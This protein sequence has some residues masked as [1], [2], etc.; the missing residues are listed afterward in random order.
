MSSAAV[1]REV[2]SGAA[3][4]DLVAEDAVM[5]RACCGG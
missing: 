3:T 2:K 4:D 5:K 1:A